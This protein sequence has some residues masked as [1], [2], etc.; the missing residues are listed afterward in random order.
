[1]EYKGIWRYVSRTNLAQHVEGLRIA[2]DEGVRSGTVRWESKWE[3]ARDLLRGGVFRGKGASI[4]LHA[5]YRFP[6]LWQEARRAYGVAQQRVITDPNLL[7]R[8]T[9]A[10][11]LLPKLLG[12]LPMAGIRSA[13]RLSLGHDIWNDYN[14]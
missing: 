9:E 7:R 8:R 11:L 14:R 1:M 2:V 13:G 3:Q 5:A 4:T 12:H 10:G 6:A